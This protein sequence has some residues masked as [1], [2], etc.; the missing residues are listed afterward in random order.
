MAT[1][2]TWI[3]SSA[4]SSAAWRW[5]WTGVWWWRTPGDQCHNC[6]ETPSW[7][8]CSQVSTGDRDTQAFLTTL[9]SGPVDIT[10]RTPH[11]RDQIDILSNR[12]KLLIIFRFLLRSQYLILIITVCC[13]KLFHWL[14]IDYFL[15]TR[16][17][18]LPETAQHLAPSISLGK[19]YD[20]PFLIKMINQL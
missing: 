7:L 9:A 6:H 14:G 17:L 2:F 19:K 8:L 16:S 1:Y 15:K 20:H 13:I 18:H 11:P 5:C 3:T 4:E 12:P 10:S